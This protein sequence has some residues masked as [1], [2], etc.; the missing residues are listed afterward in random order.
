MPIL[1]ALERFLC[2]TL[3][4][5]YTKRRK[6]M[7]YRTDQE[8][9]ELITVRVPTYLKNEFKEVLTL[10]DTNQSELIR[11]YI[12]QYIAENKSKILKQPNLF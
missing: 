4:T 9:T 6:I 5:N 7:T 11:A 8:K 3:Q 12:K 10:N 2:K 1:W